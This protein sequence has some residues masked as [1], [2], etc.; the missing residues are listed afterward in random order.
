[1]RALVSIDEEIDH[2]GLG[3]WVGAMVGLSL[4]KYHSI[5]IGLCLA[6]LRNQTWLKQIVAQH[7]VQALDLQVAIP[8]QD[9]TY[10]LAGVPP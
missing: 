5:D 7:Q 2:R 1:M 9:L 10:V 4:M 6:Y 8:R 3:E